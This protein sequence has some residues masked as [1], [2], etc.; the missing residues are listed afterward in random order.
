M[1]QQVLDRVR[2]VLDLRAWADW[3]AQLDRPF[4]FLLS[5]PFVVVVVALWAA[6]RNRETNKE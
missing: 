3:F 6:Q 4:V 2:E 1:A 5:L